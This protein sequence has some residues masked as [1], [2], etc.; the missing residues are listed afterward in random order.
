MRANYQGNDG[1]ANTPPNRNYITI[2]EDTSTGNTILGVLAVYRVTS[3][4]Y[5]TYYRVN[6]I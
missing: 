4:T 3:P 2:R 6:Y 5:R 1:E